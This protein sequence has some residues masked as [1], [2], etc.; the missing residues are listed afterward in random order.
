MDIHGSLTNGP[1]F[2]NGVAV[3]PLVVQ[4]EEDGLLLLGGRRLVVGLGRGQEVV[5]ALGH[6]HLQ[7]LYALQHPTYK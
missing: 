5:G 2:G 4:V 1:L 6:H 3:V 7:A